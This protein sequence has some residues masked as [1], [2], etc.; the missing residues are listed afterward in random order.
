MT[1]VLAGAFFAMEPAAPVSLFFYMVGGVLVVVVISFFSL[2]THI[3]P[4]RSRPALKEAG[5]GDPA[6]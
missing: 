4:N 2:R 3:P 5:A 1:S 6:H